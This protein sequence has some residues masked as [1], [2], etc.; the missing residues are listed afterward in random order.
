M[1]AHLIL[2]TL[3]FSTLAAWAAE[4]PAAAAK[5]LTTLMEAAI[6]D[7]HARFQSLGDEAFKKGI[8]AEAFSSVVKQL[9]PLLKDGYETEFLTELT[10][11]G[12]QIYLWKITPRAGDDQFIA[13]LVLSGDK[14]A[15]FWIQ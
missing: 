10:Q 13:K 5:S 7:D 8:T 4:P 9:Q 12:H 6:R 1:K 15:G 11:H 2:V 3:L 14:V